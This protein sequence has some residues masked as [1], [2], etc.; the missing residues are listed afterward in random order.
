MTVFVDI[1]YFIIL[2]AFALIVLYILYNMFLKPWWMRFIK[3]KKQYKSEKLLSM[4]GIGT[5]Y[6]WFKSD[7]E[8][9]KSLNHRDFIYRVYPGKEEM[10]KPKN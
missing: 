6:D 9:I 7:E 10:I 2:G 1:K 4:G 8:A 3:R 5:S